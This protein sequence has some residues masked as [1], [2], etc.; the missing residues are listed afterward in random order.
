MLQFTKKDREEEDCKLMYVGV[1]SAR[2]KINKTF[3]KEMHLTLVTLD[4]NMTTQGLFMQRFTEFQ[5][6][7]ALCMSICSLACA[8][9]SVCENL[10]RLCFSA[11]SVDQSC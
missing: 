6:S 1:N 9:E 8:H 7:N 3:A 10:S 5:S 2:F 11:W 4:L